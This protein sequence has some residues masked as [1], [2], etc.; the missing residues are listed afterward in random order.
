VTDP[1]KAKRNQSKL[2]P[3]EACKRCRLLVTTQ[4]HRIAAEMRAYVARVPKEERDV[5][6]KLLG[7][8]EIVVPGEET[9]I[10]LLLEPVTDDDPD[11]SDD[12][13]SRPELAEY[14]ARGVM[15]PLPPERA[16]VAKGRRP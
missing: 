1:V 14:D 7:A 2:S 5:C 6:R 12:T 4:A 9:T 16:A 10:S 3:E 11:H 13:P 15:E 8:L